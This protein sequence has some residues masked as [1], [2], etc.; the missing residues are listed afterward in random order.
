MN[1]PV[2]CF[3]CGVVALVTCST[4][5]RSYCGS[6]ADPERCPNCLLPWLEIFDHDSALDLVTDRVSQTGGPPGDGS[7]S[8]L[9]WALAVAVRTGCTAQEIDLASARGRTLRERRRVRLLERA[10]S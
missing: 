7:S 9:R 8:R 2:T 6:H 1:G 3:C 5:H 4:C 10:A